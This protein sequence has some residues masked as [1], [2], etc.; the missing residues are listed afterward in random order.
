MGSVAASDRCSPFLSPGCR[1]LVHADRTPEPQLGRSV[2]RAW[3]EQG[4]RKRSS[5]WGSGRDLPLLPVGALRVWHVC[6]TGHDSSSRTTCGAGR[7]PAS[8]LVAVIYRCC[9]LEPSVCGTYVARATTLRPELPAARVDSPP[10]RWWPGQPVL[11]RGLLYLCAVQTWASS[12]TGRAGRTSPA[13]AP[14]IVNFCGLPGLKSWWQYAASAA[15]PATE[16]PRR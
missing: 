13:R 4:G 2:A 6:G 1:A 3:R 8:P 14:E 5:G 7:Q 15:V 12:V 9:P 10:P 16:A 11:V